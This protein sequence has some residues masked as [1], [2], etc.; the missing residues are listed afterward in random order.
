[1]MRSYIIQNNYSTLNTP[2]I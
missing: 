2:K 1:M